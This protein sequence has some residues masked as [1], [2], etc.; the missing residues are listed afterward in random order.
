MSILGKIGK[1]AIG[2]AAGDSICD[3]LDKAVE[4]LEKNAEKVGDNAV[5]RFNE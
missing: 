4:G 5:K 3:I 2:F 1:T